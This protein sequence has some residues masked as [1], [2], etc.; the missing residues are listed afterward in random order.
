MRI[1]IGEPLR[2]QIPIFGHLC[3]IRSEGLRFIDVLRI[4]GLSEGADNF[5]I[6]GVDA[7]V[8]GPS[9]DLD[10]YLLGYE[11]SKL[12]KPDKRRIASITC[13]FH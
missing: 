5:H 2:K 1:P 9:G 11:M 7:F 4:L 3:F 12:M 8:P 10:G 6:N 13:M